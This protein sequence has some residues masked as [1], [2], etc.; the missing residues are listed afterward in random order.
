MAVPDYQTLMLPLLRLAADRTD[1]S[2]A[3]VIENLADQVALSDDERKE[4][5][6]SGTQV[7]FDNRVRWARFYLQKAG[8]LEPIGRGR[9]RI[10]TRG[11]EALQGAPGRIDVK[12][13][14]RFP[15]FREFRSAARAE[16]STPDE[17]AVADSPQTPQEALDT[18]YQNLRRTLARELLEK[19]RAVPPRFFEKLVVD[20]LVAM[21]YGGSRKD[22]GQAVGGSGDGGVDGVIKQD[23]LGLDVVY[24]QAKRW[25]ATIGRPEIQGFA[26]SLD[27]HRAQ[28][29][30]FITTSRFSREA[31]E[32]VRVIPKKII[33][34]DGERLAQMMIDHGVGVAEIERYT[35]KR[36]DL[37]YFEEGE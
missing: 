2:I 4:L 22:A 23:P 27:G 18:S 21:G 6:P 29:G 13:L 15:E 24:I 25:E 30:V 14:D 26:G 9:F 1:Q 16:S 19:V 28:K 20:L 37:D 33:L 10:T 3:Q 5:L 35:V 7:K 11:L 31:E 34:I 8:L 17:P 32:Y 12:F 36:I